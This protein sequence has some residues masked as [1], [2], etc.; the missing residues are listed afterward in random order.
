MS[1]RNT[2]RHPKRK[3]APPDT[4]EQRKIERREA[5]LRY[6]VREAERK[7]KA[8][9]FASGIA[10]TR[11]PLD[12]KIRRRNEALVAVRS[13]AREA[14]RARWAEEDAAIGIALPSHI[15]R[16]SPDS[17]PHDAINVEPNPNEIRRLHRD[18][19]AS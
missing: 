9:W 2:H 14:L 7:V 16:L 13:M 19:A 4:P 1:G 11:I 3:P 18:G 5:Q 15:T 10:A 12:E 17:V 8:A 6:V